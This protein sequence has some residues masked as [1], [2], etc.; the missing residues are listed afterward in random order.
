M[1][2]RRFYTR[3]RVN[4]DVRIGTTSGKVYKAEL[5][6]LS[7]E[8]G[9]IRL[10]DIP[11]LNQGDGVYLLIKFKQFNFK[12]KAE[13]RWIKKDKFVDVGLKFKEMTMADRQV[14]SEILS[15]IALANLEDSF[16]R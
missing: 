4:A 9:R 10:Y 12:A 15:E 5:V 11:D 1:Q 16:L 3:Y 14:L 7:A 13:V 8:G 2:N 6:D